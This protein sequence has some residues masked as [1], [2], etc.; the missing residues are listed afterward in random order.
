[1]DARAVPVD[2][3]PQ[4]VDGALFPICSRASPCHRQGALPAERWSPQWAVTRTGP[5]ALGPLARDVA[6]GATS[7]HGGS[8]TATEERGSNGRK[9]NRPPHERCRS[10]SR[11]HRGTWIPIGAGLPNRPLCREPV[12]CEPDQGGARDRVRDSHRDPR[13]GRHQAS[14]SGWRTAGPGS[15]GPARNGPG[16]TSVVNID[17]RSSCSS[18]RSM[19]C[20]GHH[21]KG[22]TPFLQ[23]S[24]HERCMRS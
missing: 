12:A 4:P 19:T 23:S 21:S 10:T 11:P 2:V 22:R 1:M 14:Q 18:Q 3:R 15:M 6:R 8:A 7:G 17:D 13:H 5:C 20:S 9:P 24:G 16:V